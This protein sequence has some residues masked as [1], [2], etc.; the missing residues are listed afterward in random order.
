MQYQSA[1]EIKVKVAGPRAA[2]RRMIESGLNPIVSIDIS[3][4]NEGEFEVNVPVDR[5]DVPFGV[6]VVSIK[7]EVIKIRVSKKD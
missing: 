1:A 3:R 2:L 7:P 6:K 4:R 5:I